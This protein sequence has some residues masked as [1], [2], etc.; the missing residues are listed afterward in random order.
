MILIS[1]LFHFLIS[2]K[3]IKKNILSYV[4]WICLGYLMLIIAKDLLNET[5]LFFL[6]QKFLNAQSILEIIINDASINA[7]VESVYFSTIG[8][9]KN[10][11]IPGGL[12]SFIEMRREISSLMEKEI[13]YN[14]VESNKIMSWA[15]SLLYE[16]GIFGLLIMVLFFKSIYKGSL[17]SFLNCITL[18]LILFSAIPVAFPLISILL[19]LMVYNKK[20]QILNQKKIHSTLK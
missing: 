2:L 17:R 12:D 6:I 7:R 20:I 16:L 4:I 18:F 14:R 8:S 1:N 9:F 13:F 3:I 19:S 5:R 11:L 10:Y 15:G